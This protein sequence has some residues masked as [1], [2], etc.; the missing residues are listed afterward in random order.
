M[1]NELEMRRGIQAYWR[2]ITR[3]LGMDSPKHEASDT[4]MLGIAIL[5]DREIDR[6][7]MNPEFQIRDEYGV[8]VDWAKLARALGPAGRAALAVRVRGK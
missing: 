6:M 2:V 4:Y 5:N 1:T 3:A 8:D 7:T